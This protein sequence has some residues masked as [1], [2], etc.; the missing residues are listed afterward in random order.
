MT[1]IRRS[2]TTAL[3]RSFT[4]NDGQR[5]L[6]VGLQSA[7]EDV[8]AGPLGSDEA[9]E[10]RHRQPA[11]LNRAIPGIGAEGSKGQGQSLAVARRAAAAYHAA[12]ARRTLIAYA[13]QIFLT[14]C[15]RLR[16]RGRGLHEF[17]ERG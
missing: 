4:P 17:P 13:R 9:S 1:R 6:H 7:L 3:G 2:F 15:G 16:S 14:V 12:S 10:E 11:A 5:F 8:P